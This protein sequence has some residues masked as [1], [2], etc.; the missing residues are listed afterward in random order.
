MFR[1]FGHQKSSILDGGLPR[2]ETE[3]FETVGGTPTGGKRSTYPT[4]VL[5]GASVRCE[6]SS[7]LSTNRVHSES[8]W[9]LMN[10]W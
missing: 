1:A 5:D 6:T 4:P 10:R 2:W 9:Q 3:G 8:R 7:P